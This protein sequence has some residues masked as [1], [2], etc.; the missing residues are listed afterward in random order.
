MGVK[1]VKLTVNGKAYQVVA[2]EDLTLLDLLRD[3]LHLTGAKQSCDKAGQCGACTV[4]MNGR[5]VRSCLVKVGKLDGADVITVEGLGTPDNPHL[6]QE[7]FVLAGAIQ[8]GF[9]TPGMIMATKALLDKNND[10][11]TEEIKKALRGNLCRCTGYVKIIDAVKLAGR[12]LRGEITPDEVRPDPDGPKAGVSHPRPSALEKACGTARYTA[13]YVLPGALEL[14]AVHSPYQHAIIKKID[15]SAAEKMP[16]VVGFMTAKDIKGTNRLVLN[17]ND[18]PLLC[19]DRVRSF[20]DPVAVVAARTR[21]EAREA[22]KAVKVEYEPLPVLTSPEEALAEDAPQIHPDRPNLCF[23]HPQIKGD[24]KEALQK[25]AAVVEGHF[26]TQINHQAPLEPEASVAYL[27]EEDDGDVQLVVVGRSINI[28]KH[29][30]TLQDA[31]GYENIR[32]E[33]AVSGGQ[34]GIKVEI[35][36]EGIAGAAALHFKQPVRYIPSLEESMWLTPKRH[37]YDMKVKLAADSEGKLTAYE[38]DF[39]VD[40]GAYHSNGDVIINRSLRMLSGSYNIPNVHAMSRLVYTNNPWGSSARGAGPPQTNFA[41][42]CAVNMLADK[43]GI[44]PLEFR[45][46]NSLQPG[47]SKSTGTVVTEWPFPVVCESLKPHY[48]RAKREAK[49]HKD[50]TIVRGVGI[51]AGSF[52][53]GSPG[54]KAIVSI[55]LDPDGGVTVYAAVADPGEGNESMLTQLAAEVLKLP[56]HKIRLVTRDTD[57]T[58][59]TGPAAGSRMTYMCGGA[60]VDAANQLKAAMA[61]CGATCHDD[62]VRAGKPTRYTGTKATLQSGP[63]DKET[64]QGSAYESEVHALQM[65]EVEVNK[66]TGEVRIIKMT[67]AVDSGPVIN[68][69]NYEG[70]LEGGADMGAGFALREQFIA[71]ETKD[72][73]TFKFPTMKTA[74]PMEAV[75]T[76]TPRQRGTLHGSTGVGEMTMVPTAPAVISAIY[77]AIGVWICDLPATPEK[78]KAALNDEI[79]K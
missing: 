78:I 5:A 77:D 1:Q 73:V 60:L 9:C 41:L 31:L 55:E 46:K 26:K 3:E 49:Q 33:E 45:L 8:C 56:L 14:A 16:G 24:A 17:T 51:A 23:T 15:F 32:Y 74:F 21:K 66:E 69:L 29:L 34:F 67:T 44:D 48:E 42:E 10:P 30:S 38:I 70:Q 63:L 58:T 28:H 37:P 27:E 6:I 50:G 19:E 25:A 4:I 72:W 36:S 18:R 54:D 65:A 11:D 62:L 52:G 40:N 64:G 20:G 12:F 47:L 53:I 35:T 22:A 79:R 39:T 59:A 57:R 7:A 13:D 68:R 43:M 75:I 61:E 2:D 71:Q 76:E